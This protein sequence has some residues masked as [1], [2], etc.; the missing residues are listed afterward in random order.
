M[1]V[2][3]HVKNLALIEEVDV[4]FGEGLVVLTGETGAGKS[5]V[6]G[7]VN[8]AL[9]EKASK[10]L[11]RTGTDYSLVELTFKV[12]DSL[13]DTLK[14]MDIYIEDDS[15][16]VVTRKI[17]KDRSVA[18]INGETV[19]L[20]TLKAAMSLLVDI[21]GQHEHQT[22]LYKKNHLSFL[23]DYAKNEIG[24]C[25]SKV[26]E[27]YN[28]YKKLLKALEEMQMDSSTQAKELEFAKFEIKE[29]ESANLTEGEDETL[30]ADFKKMNNSQQ[31]S[32]SLSEAYECLTSGDV[33]V[34]SALSK[35]IDAVNRISIGDEEIE[36]IKKSLY[37]IDSLVSQTSSDISDYNKTLEYD[38]ARVKEVEERLDT[39][40]TLKLKYGQTIGLILDY[41]KDRQDFV[42]R[43]NNYEEELEKLNVDLKKSKDTLEKLSTNLSSKRKKAAKEFEKKVV[44]ALED[45]NFLSVEFKV[46]FKT[47]ELS[48]DG[49]DDVEFMLSTNPGEPLK[50]LGD[51]A[52]GG[53]LSRIMLAIKS[54]M[55]SADEVDTLIFDEIDAGIS[56]KTATAVGEK[57]DLLARRNQVI[58]I[59]HLSQIASMADSH[60]LIS[61]SVKNDKTYSEVEKLDR[62]ASV[63]ELARL[64]G[65]IEDSD[66]A[67][68]HAEELKKEAESKKS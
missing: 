35:A 33:N 26:F 37:D 62:D 60:F 34:S 3:L 1:L 22:L 36:N 43:I 54:V 48:A 20:K 38:P 7:S 42:D 31:T 9:G 58:C 53:E 67:I 28:N 55:A 2:N 44:K 47:K 45:L 57:L 40:N 5:L 25:L 6:I 30:E 52:S 51:V 41:L 65:G 15:E 21:Y 14:A 29:I 17:S 64:S 68:K 66:L 46:D 24:D 13:A 59:S 8:L 61:K 63:K 56:G 49:I 39:I 12:S 27:E 18:K 16:V 32:Q 11:I 10:D 19:N 50:P 4:D 23:D